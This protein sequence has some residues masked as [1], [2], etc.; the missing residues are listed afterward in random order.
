MFAELAD[1]I[2]KPE[3]RKWKENLW[4]RPGTRQKGL[5]LNRKI[6]RLLGL[7]RVERA[8]RAG[9]SMTLF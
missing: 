9:E 7:D 8:G 2:D 5:K 1:A 3:R 4:I 6:K